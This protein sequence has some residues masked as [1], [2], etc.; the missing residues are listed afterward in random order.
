MAVFIARSAGNPASLG[1]QR[2]LF[3]PPTDS[4]VYDAAIE[5][6]RHTHGE[7]HSIYQQIVQRKAEALPAS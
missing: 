7:A 1:D 2:P 5:I 6:A 4:P 3:G